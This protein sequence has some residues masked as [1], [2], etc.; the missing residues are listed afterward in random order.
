MWKKEE[1]Q[2][3]RPMAESQ[4]Q[5][6]TPPPTKSSGRATIGPSI[7]IRGDVTGSED[8]LIQGQIDGSVTLADHSVGVGSKGRVNANII[9]R[10]ITIEGRVEGDLTAQEQ[11][12]LRGSSNVKGDIKAPRVVLEDGATFRGLVDMGSSHAT[13]HDAESAD[14]SGDES[15]SSAR[16]E[17]HEG[18]A[19]ALADAKPQT[20]SKT[21]ATGSGLASRKS[22][23]GAGAPSSK[24]SGDETESESQ[25][26]EA[27][28]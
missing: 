23:A 19:T 10:L 21:A 20:R 14:A 6:A 27:G 2:I 17:S 24:K 4:P 26:K 28:A 3:G 13:S 8:L 18:R 5:V 25:A 12:V 7:S 16:S 15:A 11:I 1:E 9:G 22:T